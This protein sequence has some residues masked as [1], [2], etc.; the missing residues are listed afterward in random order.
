M[1][2]VAGYTSFIL[3]SAPYPPQRCLLRTL[4]F[5]IIIH[6]FVAIHSSIP[7]IKFADN[8]VVVSLI[9]NSA[10]QA[11]SKQVPDLAQ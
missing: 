8:T 4:L 11:Y 7:I 5:S 10:E 2:K 1:V 3:T 6:D 9:M